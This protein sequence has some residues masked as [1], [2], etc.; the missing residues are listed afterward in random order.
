MGAREVRIYDFLTFKGCNTASHKECVKVCVNRAYTSKSN[1]GLAKSKIYHNFVCENRVAEA[2]GG[3]PPH[4]YKLFCQVTEL[5]GQPER[6]FAD[7][8]F[9]SVSLPLPN[10]FEDRLILPTLK[11]LGKYC[12]VVAFMDYCRS[13]TE[14]WNHYATGHEPEC[15]E[16]ENPH[17]KWEGGETSALELLTV[18]LLIEKTVSHTVSCAQWWWK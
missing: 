2:N 13:V 7:P 15:P 14:S 18:R 5:L 17:N 3:R 12:P 1:I 4:T 8:D 10:D 11:E 9:S 6:P 16:Q